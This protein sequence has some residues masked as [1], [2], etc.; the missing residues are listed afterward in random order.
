MIIKRKKKI[1]GP[2]EKEIE[3]SILNY[4]IAKKIFCWKQNSVGVFDPTRGRFRRA[5][6]PYIINGVADIL[7][8]Y[9]GRFLAI[10]VKVPSRKN[11]LTEHQKKFIKNILESGGVAFV[12]TS[13]E[14]VKQGLLAST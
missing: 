3:N 5:N 7:G 1:K 13:I 14:D 6:N 4:L 10:E 9:K 12:A 2:L 11:N 8:V